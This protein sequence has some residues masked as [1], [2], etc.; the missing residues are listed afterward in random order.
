MYELIARWIAA[1]RRSK[2]FGSG[3]RE[4]IRS[5]GDPQRPPDGGGDNNLVKPSPMGEGDTGKTACQACGRSDESQKYCVIVHQRVVTNATNDEI[6]GVEKTP[7]LI[8]S[9]CAAWID[10]NVE[11]YLHDCEK[12]M[13]N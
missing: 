3:G 1:R 11:F 12:G 6:L 7:E 4:Y 5:G 9:V 13:E 8:C 2:S 10:V